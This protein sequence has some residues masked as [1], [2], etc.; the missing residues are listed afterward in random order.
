MFAANLLLGRIHAMTLPAKLWDFFLG[1]AAIGAAP[2]VAYFV[3][4]FGLERTAERI[5]GE[6]TPHDLRFVALG[7]ILFAIDSAAALTALFFVCRWRMK[8]RLLP[9]SMFW[10]EMLVGLIVGGT[11]FLILCFIWATSD[12]SW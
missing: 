7:F 9:V 3:V 4:G 12:P 5:F 10:A 2:V 1:A 6:P 11:Y 8:H